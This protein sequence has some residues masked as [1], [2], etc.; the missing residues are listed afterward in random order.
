VNVRLCVAAAVG[1]TAWTAEA[2]QRTAVMPGISVSRELRYPTEYESQSVGDLTTR[3]GANPTTG[4]ALDPYRSRP[5]IPSAFKTRQLGASVSVANIGV[6]Q[7]VVTRK[8]ERFVYHARF[9][10]GYEADFSDGFDTT[11]NGR[12]YRGMGLR[13]GSYIVK[14]MDSGEIVRFTLAAGAVAKK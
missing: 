8:A 6:Q 11:V 5:P 9:A 7:V 2:Q 10:N 1:M 4:F 12:R 13:A 3:P 14:D